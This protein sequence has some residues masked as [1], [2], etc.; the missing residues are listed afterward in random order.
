MSSVRG[1]CGALVN[2]LRPCVSHFGDTGRGRYRVWTKSKRYERAVS[3]RVKR[4]ESINTDVFWNGRWRLHQI[5]ERL[6]GRICLRKHGIRKRVY[7]WTDIG[8]FVAQNARLHHLFIVTVSKPERDARM[9]REEIFQRSKSYR[10]DQLCQR[11]GWKVEDHRFLSYR[12]LLRRG[13]TR[14]PAPEWIRP[15]FRARLI[16]WVIYVRPPR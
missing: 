16:N 8:K 11:I 6:I 13:I 15:C 12:D 9:C 2:S 4:S 14:E 1:D 7:Y 5:R 3:S 10:G